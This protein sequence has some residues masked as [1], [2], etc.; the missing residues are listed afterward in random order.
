MNIIRRNAAD[1][2]AGTPF[3]YDRDLRM[4]KNLVRMLRSLDKEEECEVSSPMPV[5]PSS[6]PVFPSQKTDSMSANQGDEL[7]V[8]WGERDDDTITSSKSY[9]S[10]SNKNDIE[11]LLVNWSDDCG[12]ELSDDQ[13]EDCL[14][15]RR[16]RYRRAATR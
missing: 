14:R 5:P 6:Q 13:E 15:H 4:S 10:F 3:E 7:L 2:V 1:A 9:E 11:G 8:N 12:S 16:S